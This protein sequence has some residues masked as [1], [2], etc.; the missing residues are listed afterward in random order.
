MSTHTPA[1]PPGPVFV[2]PGQGSY[3]PLVV[4]ALY[5]GFPELHSHF[6][7]ADR[8][9]RR[10]LRTDFL[11]LVSTSHEDPEQA[12]QRCPD[13]DQLGI[14][15][16]EVG[17]AQLLI[18]KGVRPAL[19]LGHSFG[20][21]AALTIAGVYDVSTGLKIVC[22]RVLALREAAQ[23]GAMAALSADAAD[24]GKLLAELGAHALDIAVINHPRQTVV[25]GPADQ[26]DAL[27]T[28]AARRGVSLTRLKSRYPFHSRLLAKAVN[29]FRAN[30]AAYEFGA[31]H[32]PVFICTEGRR[33]TAEIDLADALAMQFVRPL[34][35]RELV[36]DVYGQGF[37]TF[38]EC[39]AGAITATLI[40]RTLQHAGDVVVLP[41]LAD[42]TNVVERLNAV[43]AQLLAQ[44]RLQ[45]AELPIAANVV[46]AER[47]QQLMATMLGDLGTLVRDVST[48]VHNTQ[49]LMQLATRVGLAGAP[50]GDIRVPPID[51]A[52]PTLV[53]LDGSTVSNVTNDSAPAVNAAPPSMDAPEERCRELPIAIVSMGCVLPGADDV[54]HYWNNIVEGVSG[55]VDLAQADPAMAQDF[56][57]G[58]VSGDVS[59]IVP[60][61]TYTLL[62]GTI[63]RIPYRGNLLAGF[64]RE[65]DFGRLT[66]GQRLLALAMGQAL[67]E[68]RTRDA[69]DSR[70][71]VECILG[72]T[73]DGSSEYDDARFVD[74]VSHAL[75]ELNEPA[76][77]R[78]EFERLA[79]DVLGCRPGNADA[80]AQ[81]TIYQAVI[82]RLIN[83]SCRTF[84]V[85][86][87]CSS[88]LYSIHL[89]IKALKSFDADV[90]FAGGVFAP[91]AANNTLF[92]QFRGLTPRQSR[93]LDAGA[94]G[95]VFGDGA[96]ILALK[97]LPDALAD[98]DRVLGVIR[99]IGISS[100]GKSPSINVPQSK[101]Q[102]QAMRRAYDRSGIELDSIQYVEAHATAT[103]VGDAVEFSALKAVMRQRSAALAPIELGSVKALI[104]HTGWVSGAASV[105]KLC[106]AFEARVMPKQHHFEKPSAE[107]G[108]D[109]SPFA[110]SAHSRAWPA[111]IHGLPRRAGI[112]G[113][114]F[115]GTNAHLILEEFD[116]G[117]HRRVARQFG[118]NMEIA[119]RELSVVAVA[120]LFPAAT[121]LAGDDVAVD[122][123]ARFR[124]DLKRLPPKKLLLPDVLEHMD[125]SQF[126]APLAA[127]A[128]LAAI[129][130]KWPSLKDDIGVVVGLESKTE[131]GVRA[132]ERIYL[133]RLQRLV[134]ARSPSAEIER[135]LQ[136]VVD[137]LRQKNAPSG[138]Y[139]LPGLMPNVAASR[140]CHLFDLGGPN[141]VVDMGSRSL[142]Q[143]VWVAEQLLRDGDCRLV[144]A[145]GLHAAAERG[146]AEAALLLGLCTP[147]T[148]RE[149]G[150]PVV[151]RL[152]L[153]ANAPAG[154][155]PITEHGGSAYRGAQGA[156]ELNA[157]IRRGQRSIAEP[158]GAGPARGV[159]VTSMVAESSQAAVPES[160][161][162][163]ASGASSHAYVQSTPIYGFTPAMVAA[164][165][166]GAA[167][168]SAVKRI[169]FIT[170]NADRWTAL[171][172]GGGLAG[173]SHTVVSP[174]GQ[175]LPGGIEIDTESEA[176]LAA[177]MERLAGVAYDAII[178]VQDL[179]G[180]EPDALLTDIDGRERLLVDVLFAV[181][182][183]A[184]DALA[185]GR[186]ALASLS[187]NAF[188]DGVLHPHTGLVAG[189]L[190]S[191]AREL[192]QAT[193]RIVNTDAGDLRHGLAQATVEIG[194][195]YP[196]CEVC[197]RDDVRHVIKLAPVARLAEDDVPYLGRDAVVLAT[198]GGRGVTAVMAEELL[199]RFGCTVIAVG[200]TDLADAPDVIRDMDEQSFRQ[201]EA[202]F[203][204]E[205]L[206][207]GKGRKIV[208]VKRQ[209]QAY[210]AVNEL[211]QTIKRLSQLGGRFE[212]Q[213]LDI[214]NV[215]AVERLVDSVYDRYGR[216]DLVVHGAGI[217]LSKMLLKKPLSEFRSVVA[218]KLASLGALYRACRARAGDRPVHY[219]LLTSA[220]SYMGNDGQPD[221]GAAN[222]AMNRIA[223]AM[224]RYGARCNWS[225][226]A[227]LGWAGI[228]MTR[229]SEYAALAANR[230]LRG[231]TKAEGQR[232]FG[233]L[234][235]GSPRAPI[236]ILMADGEMAFYGIDTTARG[237]DLIAQGQ[238]A[239]AGPTEAR[240][241]T[242]RLSWSVS[243][244]N[245]PFLHDHV[246]NGIPTLPAA[247]MTAL[248]AEAARQIRPDL[249]I[250]AFEDTYYRKF[251]RVP[252]GRAVEVHFD[253]EVSSETAAECVVR[254]SVR[255]DFVHRNGAILQRDV[256]HKET[257]VRMAQTLAVPPARRNG[258]LAEP[259]EFPDPYVMNGSVVRLNG[260]F[261]TMSDIRVS[262]SHRMA[263]YRLNGARYPASPFQHLL[264]N[265]ILVD[266]FWRFGAIH[267]PDHQ[268]LPVYVPE[269]CGAM[270]VY[271]DYVQFDAPILRQTLTFSGA[272]PRADGDLLR[273]GDIEVRDPQGNILLTVEGATCRYFGEVPY[274]AA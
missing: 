180:R 56:L 252:E 74:S 101:G 100:D 169:L 153:H 129:P 34:N 30:L 125:L 165:G 156:R 55:I 105:I 227:W 12:L 154:A 203:Y 92:A 179:D 170:D 267:S 163:A 167:S 242:K 28:I 219:H 205:A 119:D 257:N 249:K 173:V 8:V 14:Y 16:T 87:A 181:T 43:H 157:A 61:K 112:N 190:K 118:A 40:Q 111:N 245:T 188:R 102:M 23:A 13:L 124:R 39:G 211:S 107:F 241:K 114:G 71:R 21:L 184:H 268:R 31:P 210:Q 177:S 160:A 206:A 140:I 22:Q 225:S 256:L 171:V 185:S 82:A 149:L 26:L 93:P 2:F 196:L 235:T 265:L 109:D 81:H 57:G 258:T 84:V 7:E 239:D 224:H 53:A 246:V 96:A 77:R 263:S 85:D 80:I 216:I 91:G 48:L 218:T 274:A 142:L 193:V 89:G 175:T 221:Y 231:I 133:D 215:E 99:G 6:H 261:K 273:L 237:V 178:A 64:Y 164:P 250:V 51:V 72:A 98:G 116:D 194:S 200:R 141:L 213:S 260:A 168:A 143:A 138:A 113:F 146:E 54:A 38:V 79:A 50:V 63:L 10:F 95:V 233:A 217:Q 130:Q 228:G 264:A 151:A 88:S 166:D 103:P 49:A 115:G 36:E 183:H 20:D 73:A 104:G 176:A 204:R 259:R 222:E 220:F 202:E 37:R 201:Y 9:A 255:S 159:T 248:V 262:S 152:Q 128:V 47:V 191:I 94:D 121:E 243:L 147:A 15:V 240:T 135:L 229:G 207:Q 41:G 60:D 137:H 117:Y 4:Q 131:Q 27:G 69:L 234:M 44:G 75:E 11:S 238:V 158:V 66:R 59:K 42:D 68:L 108:I 70:A 187:L 97:R 155:A 83:P 110:I 230:G 244:E 208:E 236:N 272:N 271:F 120:S 45:S 161:T 1:Q 127:D 24:T 29:A 226:L 192:P 214:N 132:N 90:V 3:R 17:L 195:A 19:L 33:Y 122:A 62:N 86:S 172:R 150:L 25:S 212:Y 76:E 145:G 134:R 144:L 269:Y 254:V 32:T 58:R 67:S 266:S 189:C 35:F 136:R 182:R 126:L 65:D 162:P 232:I 223:A 5:H 46:P 78:A 186:V 52:L 123:P 18:R 174:R 270:R 198:G 251:V 148:A 106:K 209:Y 199:R 247:F 139:T 253:T 197:Y